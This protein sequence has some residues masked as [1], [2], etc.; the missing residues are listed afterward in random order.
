[1]DC[2]SGKVLLV[3]IAWV[4]STFTWNL[5][6]PGISPK[7]L[8]IARPCAEV[9]QQKPKTVAPIGMGGGKETAGK[10]SAKTGSAAKSEKMIENVGKETTN[11]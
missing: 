7:D 6:C 3:G 5:T 9:N 8:V 4:L 2:T 11:I 1:M 10:A